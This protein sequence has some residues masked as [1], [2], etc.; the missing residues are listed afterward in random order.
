MAAGRASASNATYQFQDT[1]TVPAPVRDRD[2]PNIEAR[3]YEVRIAK[4]S[5]STRAYLF[6]DPTGAKPVVGRIMLLKKDLEPIMAFRIL[7]TFAE[8]KQ[9]I[10]KR[11]RRY[12]NHEDLTLNESLTAL[13]RVNEIPLPGSMNYSTEDVQDMKELTEGSELDGAGA[14]PAPRGA[15]DFFRSDDMTPPAPSPSAAPQPEIPDAPAPVASPPAEEEKRAPA[16]E[17]LPDTEE[18]DAELDAGSSPSPNGKPSDRIAGRVSRNEDDEEVYDPSALQIEEVDPIDINR[19][20]LA[21]QFGFF[22]NL[23]S[24]GLPTY[25]TG[26]GVRYG[27]TLGKMILLSRPKLQDDFTIEGGIFMY[28]INGYANETDSFS[29]LPLVATARYTIHTSENFAIFFYGGVMKNQASNTGPEG[30]TTADSLATLRTPVTSAGGGMIFRLG[31]GWEA[32]A[33]LGM[34]MIAMGLVVRF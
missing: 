5:E 24:A 1:D 19:H 16:E 21:G 25:F 32:R 23:T 9:F 15:P 4:K 31:P 17:P 28:R 13:E 8:N 6:D 33:D 26:G 34:D 22:K 12:G 27:L 30:D 11:V 2:L 14:F 20:A 3:S 10:A 29:V 7:R 18:Y